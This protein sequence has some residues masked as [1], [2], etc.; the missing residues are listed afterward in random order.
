MT[1]LGGARRLVDKLHTYGIRGCGDQQY[2]DPTV[3]NISAVWSREAKGSPRPWRLLVKTNA[4]DIG[5]SAIIT[6]REVQALR[7]K[8]RI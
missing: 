1:S 4:G 3:M 2:N 6:T 7:R 5:R 8:P